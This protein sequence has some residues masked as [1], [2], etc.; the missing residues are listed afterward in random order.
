MGAFAASTFKRGINF[1]NVPTTLLSMVDA[2]TGGKTGIDL[3]NLKNQIG[4]FSF[5]EF[6]L[7]DIEFLNT[8]DQR[9]MQS[10][11][12]EMLK[13]GLIQSFDH[14]SSLQNM[15]DL[16]FDDLE[17]LIFDSVEI[18][19][20]V[21]LND[22][23]EKGLRKI[24]NFGHTIGHAIESHFMDN[25]KSLLHG[26]AVAIG[27]IT[28]AFL[29]HS[30]NGLS[31]SELD[32]ITSTITSYF[33]KIEIPKSIYPLI[34]DLMKHD[35]KNSEN[36]INFSLLNKIGSCDFDCKA[37]EKEILESLDYYNSI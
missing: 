12:G 26:E 13:H 11:L 37:S 36:Q 4:L 35:K 2:S 18:K 20:N 31:K 17:E 7:I 19:H 15:D 14:W 27:M 6:V 34:L 25:E 16:D 24:L 3:G 8:L 10:G 29:S 30:N 5:P 32:E 28:E 22:P 21:V 23:E 9:Q 33:G 1:I